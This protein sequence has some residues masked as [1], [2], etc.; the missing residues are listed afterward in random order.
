MDC[1][2]T[3]Y[4]GTHFV[5]TKPEASKVH[6]VD[7]AHALSM[8]CRGNGHVKTFFQWDS[9]VSTALWKQRQEGFPAELSLPAFYTTQAR[10]I[11]QMCRGRL[12]NIYLSTSS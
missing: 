2:I 8:I 1:Y 6:I 7:I 12:N 11:C 5:P 3:T 10:L 4:S 9:T